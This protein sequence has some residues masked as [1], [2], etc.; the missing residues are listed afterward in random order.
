MD[1]TAKGIA[2]DGSDESPDSNQQG[3]VHAVTSVYR[4]FRNANAGVVG[5]FT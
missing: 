2:S 1:T 5:A 3:S 4:A